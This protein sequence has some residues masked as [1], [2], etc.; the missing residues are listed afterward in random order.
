MIKLIIRKGSTF[1]W[2]LRPE[3]AAQV[4]ADASGTDATAVSAHVVGADQIS[5]GM[6]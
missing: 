3:T 5:W 6:Q 2:T 4:G 1:L